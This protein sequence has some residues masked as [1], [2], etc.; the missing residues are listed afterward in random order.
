MALFLERNFRRDDLAE[1][2][3]WKKIK[4][5]EYVAE[6]LTDNIDISLIVAAFAFKK[7]KHDRK[8]ISKIST[9]GGWLFSLSKTQKN[10]LKNEE[11]IDN[12]ITLILAIAVDDSG[13][14][15]ILKNSTSD[16][17]SIAEEYANAGVE[18]FYNLIL[19]SESAEIFYKEL[20]ELITT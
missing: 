5:H 17:Q 11:K 6:Y 14:L 19:K 2:T 16:I 1:D 7:A 18:E 9:N 8:K 12:A 20:F 13:D 4:E 10:K 15:E 3:I